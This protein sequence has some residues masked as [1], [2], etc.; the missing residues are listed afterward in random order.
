MDLVDL[1]TGATLQD[2]LDVLAQASPTEAYDAGVD[3]NGL[4]RVQPNGGAAGTITYNSEI[5]E[6][7]EE[8]GGT[9][10]WPQSRK[11]SR[12]PILS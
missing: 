12:V 3:Q 1:G 5:D 9:F 4:I 8:I 10:I 6:F 7:F 11:V 2:A